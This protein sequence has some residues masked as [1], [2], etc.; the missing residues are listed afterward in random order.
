MKKILVVTLLIGLL[1]GC[2]NRTSSAFVPLPEETVAVSSISSTFG[3]L[4]DDKTFGLKKDATFQR[5]NRNSINVKSDS[6][7]HDKNALLIY[8]SKGELTPGSHF[9]LVMDIKVNDDQFGKRGDAGIWVESSYFN[10]LSLTKAEAAK[11]LK[12]S[13]NYN[14]YASHLVS[15][16]S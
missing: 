15:I 9:H 14:K 7:N 6:I 8:F 1:S 5:V 11:I 3:D 16:L 4:I 10:G 2:S 12:S 13:V